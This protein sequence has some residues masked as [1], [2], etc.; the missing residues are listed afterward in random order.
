VG[1]DGAAKPI[2]SGC[3]IRVGGPGETTTSFDPWDSRRLSFSSA[4]SGSGWGWGRDWSGRLAPEGNFT[5]RVVPWGSAGGWRVFPWRCPWAWAGDSGRNGALRRPGWR[6]RTWRCHRP[7]R[8]SPREPTMKSAPI[9]LFAF[10]T[11]CLSTVQ[12]DFTNLGFEDPDLSQLSINPITLRQEASASRILR[13]WSVFA[14]GAPFNGNV[15]LAENTVRPISLTSIASNHREVLG[16]WAVYFDSTGGPSVSYTFNQTGTIPLE[17]IALPYLHSGAG[18]WGIF[19][20]GTEIPRVRV[21]G[22]LLGEADVTAFAGK[23]VELSFRFYG[24]YH[25]HPVT[26][27]RDR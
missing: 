24:G 9:S 26:A 13:G 5:W 10:L 3:E 19:V 4:N 6:G 15:Q 12:A 17:A 27:R 2:S 18:D 16:D 8:P 23:T 1:H 11:G 21:L 22:Q 14:N 25:N 7:I 20:N